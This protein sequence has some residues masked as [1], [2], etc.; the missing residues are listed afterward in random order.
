MLF[1]I[2]LFIIVS[3]TF[4]S[5]SV[6]GIYRFPDV[7]TRIHASGLSTTL[8][9]ISFSLATIFYFFNS[10]INS[11]LLSHII[12]IT[13]ILLITEPTIALIISRTAYKNKIEPKNT[14]ID[15]LKN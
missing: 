3:L 14:I 2:Y 15:K 10:E 8:G 6:F 13:I 9:F 5:L 7:Y 12:I 4:F 1:L 11:S